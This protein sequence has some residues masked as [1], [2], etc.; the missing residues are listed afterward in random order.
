MG[1]VPLAPVQSLGAEPFPQAVTASEAAPGW[2]QPPA[3]RIGKGS[4]AAVRCAKQSPGP[5]W[6]LCL[7]R[8]GGA[9]VPTWCRPALIWLTPRLT[10]HK[11]VTHKMKSGASPGS[12]A[13]TH[14]CAMDLTLCGASLEA[15]APALLLRLEKPRV[16]FKGFILSTLPSPLTA[17]ICKLSTRREKEP[18]TI[19]IFRC[20]VYVHA[21]LS[22][23]GDAK[24]RGWQTHALLP[25]GVTQGKGRSHHPRP[26]PRTSVPQIS[27]GAGSG[28]PF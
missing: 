18:H 2:L 27:V 11:P 28:P 21:F 1:C 7:G 16:F 17:N 15:R 6:F 3:S 14:G 8:A 20:C 4:G 12:A 9:G 25:A 19:Q 5:G 22:E 13:G 26:S 10:P 24:A 23:D